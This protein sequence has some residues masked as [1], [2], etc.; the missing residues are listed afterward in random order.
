MFSP[1]GAQAPTLRSGF[2]AGQATMTAG[3]SDFFLTDPDLLRHFFEIDLTSR[4]TIVAA[5]SGGSDSTALLLLA[6]AWLDRAAPAIRLLAVTI[7]HR[8]RP[9]SAAEAKQVAR[10]CAE[11]GIAHRV[12]AWDDV[13]PASGLP[14]AA[15]VARYRLLAEAARSTGADIV[16]TGHTLDDQIET[17]SMRRARGEGRGLAGIAPATLF[18]GSIWIVRPLLALRREV[19][20]ALLRQNAI[21]WIEDP[22]NTNPDFER[23]RVRASLATDT[24][25]L[26]AAGADAQRRR[27]ALG[28]QAAALLRN[29]AANVAPG[30]I[31]LTPEFAEAPAV[32]AAIYAFRVVLAVSGG[33][34]HLPDEE[35]SACLFQRLGHR[36]FRATLSRS[37]VDARTRAIFVRR[38][39]RGLPKPETPR[40]GMVWDGRF[41]LKYT[42]GAVALTIAPFGAANAAMAV[43]AAAGAP[44][45]LVRTALAAQPALWQGDTYLGRAA[46]PGDRARGLEATPVAAP[47]AL[48]L[49]SFDL[50]LARTMTDLTGCASIPDLPFRGHNEG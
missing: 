25:G 38:E 40:D 7:D 9:E 36:A 32:E 46:G 11:H 8:L 12:I 31:R 37:V 35:R 27:T 14:A 22:T 4:R 34:P 24:A 5:I 48:F 17:V 50:A 13:K 28:E 42:T 18:D 23:A 33:M 15:R 20:R 21:G 26:W 29:E 45:S 3:R 6:K 43:A 39:L 49:P 1:S 16:L 41:R 10:F 19:L 30:L 2:D 47:W 44:Q